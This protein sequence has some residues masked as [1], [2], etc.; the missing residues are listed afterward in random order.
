MREFAKSLAADPIFLD[1]NC[2]ARLH[3]NS[4]ERYD[5]TEGIR[6]ASLLW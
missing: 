6:D 4:I 1:S 2:V 5:G 3:D